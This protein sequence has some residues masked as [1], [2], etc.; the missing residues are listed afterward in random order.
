MSS[1]NFLVEEYYERIK[2]EVNLVGSFLNDPEIVEII[3]KCRLKP[4]GYNTRFNRKLFLRKH[5]VDEFG[6]SL[7]LDGKKIKIVE[8][9]LEVDM[10]EVKQSDLY[11]G[12]PLSKI[13]KISKLMHLSI[14][15]DEDFLED[16]AVLTLLGID[17][18]FRTFCLYNGEVRRYSPLSIGLNNLR[19]LLRNMDV[20]IFNNLKN[21]G[22]VIYPCSKWSEWIV[23]LPINELFWKEKDINKKMLNELGV[24]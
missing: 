6:N 24:F 2:P 13:C 17:D 12:L 11:F 23:R 20:K 3:L 10:D 1:S 22:R 18:C 16:C 4:Y 7:I 9:N 8:N 14:G 5:W 19:K 21:E 15:T